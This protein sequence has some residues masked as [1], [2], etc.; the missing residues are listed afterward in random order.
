[1]R[2]ELK[3]YL[4]AVK[5]SARYIFYGLTANEFTREMLLFY[6]YVHTRNRTNDR[7]D[8]VLIYIILHVSE[9]KRIL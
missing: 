6:I 7:D 2:C 3:Y 5:L 4:A 8:F 9:L 1:M